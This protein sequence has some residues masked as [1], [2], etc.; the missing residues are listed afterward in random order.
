MR[1]HKKL[2]ETEKEFNYVKVVDLHKSG[3]VHFHGFF[4]RFISIYKVWS[5]WNLAIRKA[6]KNVFLRGSAHAARLYTG[7]QAARYVSKYVVKASKQ[8]EFRL[9]YYS[10]SNKISLF[11]KKPSSG[12]W[13][14]YYPNFNWDHFFREVSP[15]LVP[16]K[17]IVTTKSEIFQIFANLSEIRLQIP[18]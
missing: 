7:K 13:L 4:D 17:P 16:K 6:S 2:T 5:L 14:H 1:R 15:L 12:E 8:L 18:I 3:F 11:P 10:K 9:N